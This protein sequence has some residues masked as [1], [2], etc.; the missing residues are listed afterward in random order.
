MRQRGKTPGLA[1][2]TDGTDGMNH[3][4]GRQ[5]VPLCRLCIP[6]LTPVERPTLLEQLWSGGRVD[7]SV[8]TAAA[9]KGILPGVDD[10]IYLELGDIA[11]DQSDAVCEVRVRLGC[12]LGRCLYLACLV[13]CC[14]RWQL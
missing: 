1:I 5:V 11:L 3:I 8:Y 14:H 13:Q 12:W 4:L 6:G 7:S 10:G 9:Q 2:L